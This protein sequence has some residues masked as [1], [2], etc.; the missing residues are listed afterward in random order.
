MPV[1]LTALVTRAA[2]QAKREWGLYVL[3]FIVWVLSGIV[4]TLDGYIE[5]T[6]TDSFDS[7]SLTAEGSFSVYEFGCDDAADG[8]C[9]SFVGFSIAAGSSLFAFVLAMPWWKCKGGDQSEDA[10]RLVAAIFATLTMVALAV[11]FFSSLAFVD[12]G[13]YGV[14]FYL[15]AVALFGSIVCVGLSWDLQRKPPVE[16]FG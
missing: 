8:A 13:T 6:E 7:W 10:L 4:L 16:L 5:V 11:G 9:P 3:S 2:H 15:A 14:P 1:A 12:H